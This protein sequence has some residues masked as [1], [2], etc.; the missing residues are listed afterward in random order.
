MTVNENKMLS[1]SQQQKTFRNWAIV[2]GQELRQAQ[3]QDVVVAL[4]LHPV[5]IQGLH[6]IVG[7]D[8]MGIFQIGCAYEFHA[9]FSFF[10]DFFIQVSTSLC[11]TKPTMATAVATNKKGI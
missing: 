9:A 8:I 5:N 3:N 1:G 7:G 4:G 10:I 6:V 11:R 2:A